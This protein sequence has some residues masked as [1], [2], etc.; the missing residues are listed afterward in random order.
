MHLSWFSQ[1][2]AWPVALALVLAMTLAALAGYR[3]GHRL[4]ANSG[5]AGRG[6]FTAVQGSLIGLLALLLGIGGIKLRRKPRQQ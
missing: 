2:E 3:T 4:Q 1:L 6:H 5:D